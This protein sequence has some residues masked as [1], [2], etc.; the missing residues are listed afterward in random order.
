MSEGYR[1]TYSRR[2]RHEYGEVATFDKVTENSVKV[3][4]RISDKKPY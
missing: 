3:F 4:S 2:N 1:V